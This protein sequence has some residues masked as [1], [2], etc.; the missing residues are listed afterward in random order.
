MIRLEWTSHS[1][2][3]CWKVNQ[4]DERDDADGG[5]VSEH[6]VGHALSDILTF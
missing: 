5:A 4:G 1:D 2:K 6:V 3:G